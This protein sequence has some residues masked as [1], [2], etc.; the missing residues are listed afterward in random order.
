MISYNGDTIDPNKVAFVADW[1]RN[2]G[3]DGSPSTAQGRFAI[4]VYQIAQYYHWT[5]HDNYYMCL[6]GI[7][8]FAIHVITACELAKADITEFMPA[9]F[10][11]IGALWNPERMLQSVA[12]AQQMIC[13][14]AFTATGSEHA[15]RFKPK[16]L[17]EHAAMAIKTLMAKAAPNQRAKAV[18]LAW[19]A[20][21]N[22]EWKQ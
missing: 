13:Y 10:S 4:G 17:A 1:A 14:H 6:E 20:L 15:A 18:D 5:T 19:Q 11:S 16:K 3:R 12:C 8:A 7:G 22:R 2:F 21:D 9:K